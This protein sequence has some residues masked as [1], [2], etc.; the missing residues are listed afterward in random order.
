M[1]L[2]S[3]PVSTYSAKVRIALGLKKIDCKISTPPGG[4]STEEYMRLVPTGTI[5]ALKVGD[6]YFSESDVIMEYL[7]E[8]FPDTPLLPSDLVVRSQHRFLARYHDLWLEPHLRRTFEHM[9]PATKDQQQLD[10]HLDKFAERL[11]KLDQLFNAQPFMLA[12]KIGYAD[13][14]FAATIELADI[15]LPLFDRVLVLGPNMTQWRAAT[16]DNT[17]VKAITDESRAATLEW[18]N[19]GGG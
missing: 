10:A 12:D 19:S 2:F 14:A 17:V 7:E 1:E 18:L 8:A 5:P 6:Q 16:Q 13:C 15:L 11:L 4:Y 3:L 9:D